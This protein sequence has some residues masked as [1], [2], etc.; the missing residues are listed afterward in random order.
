MVS[1]PTKTEFPTN[2]DHKGAELRCRDLWESN[3]IYRFDSC[4][5]GEVFS[6]DTPPPY[7]SAAHL[8]VGHAMSYAQAEFIVR[9][10]RMQGY[11]VFYPMG[12]DDNGLPTERFVEK[13]YKIDK[14]TISRKEF[15][16]LCLEETQRTAATYETLWRSL[17]LSVDWSLRYSTIDERCQRIAQWSFLDLYRKGR[18][19]R[20]NEPV[21]WDTRLET[22]LAQADLETRERKSILHNIRFGSPDGISLS[23][24]TT[25]PELLPACVALYC[26]SADVRYKHLI[27]TKVKVPLFNHSVPVLSDEEV[28]E[29]F[30]TGLIMVCTFG[31]AEDVRRWKR[32]GLETRIGIRPDGKLSDIAGPYSTLTIEEGRSRIV[33]DLKSID[34]YDGGVEITQHVS[35][36]E[37]SETPVEFMLAPQWFIRVLDLKD[38]LL[39][40]SDEIRWHPD[41]MKI[42]L[43]QWISGLKYDW[44]ISR[45]RHYGVP[46]PIWYCDGC[47]E[48][49]L[50]TEAHLPLDPYESKCPLQKCAHCSGTSFKGEKDVMDTWMTSSVSPFINAAELNTMAIRPEIFPM[51]LRVQAFEIIRTW[52]F[53]TLL[54]SE[55]HT[56][57]LPW[58]NVMISGWGLNEKGKKIS[59]RELDHYCDSKGYN[60]YDPYSV[61]EKYGADALRYW[62]A[63][64]HLGN[65]ARYTE[66]EIRVGRKLVTKLWNAARFCVLQCGLSNPSAFHVPYEK[67][68]LEDRWIISEIT[69]LLPTIHRRFEEYQ[70]AQA[71][72]H[73]D[74]FFWKTFCDNYL[75]IIKDRFWRSAE[76]GEDVLC[77]TRSSLWDTLRLLLGLYAPFIPF[78]TEELY[79]LIFRPH[80]GTISIHVTAWPHYD[81]HL[82]ERSPTMDLLLDMLR[83]IRIYRTEKAISQS[84]WLPQLTIDAQA[85]NEAEREQMISSETLF[86]GA[87]RVQSIAFRNLSEGV[88]LKR[89]LIISFD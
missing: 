5:D 53:Y 18:I 48:V 3:E 78:V 84:S 11:R 81:E 31:D 27:G 8:H 10:K 58:Q 64:T 6:V 33:A 13:K 69:G 88:L 45:Q 65:D 15:R 85:L 46:I 17:G 61:I 82:I 23:I 51:S 28:D 79:Q 60:R 57:S 16:R 35:V 50:A 36:S 87:L 29:T 4:G 72:E 55:L 19:Y 14:K 1:E 21:L 63:G 59:K 41:W 73:I 52:L 12:F 62:A 25:R 9:Y 7:V 26:S 24:S 42:R 71:R 22:S 30:G 76:Y 44:N 77:G 37:R 86:R 34:A 47:G 70:Y 68:Q 32:D 74:Q 89:G 75:E 38:T 54:K 20:S 56:E 67:R 66:E 40:R 2:F 43:N 49:I 39:K 83:G 80:E